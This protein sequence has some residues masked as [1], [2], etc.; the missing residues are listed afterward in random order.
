MRCLLSTT[1]ASTAPLL[2][3][4][5]AITSTQCG[6]IFLYWTAFRPEVGQKKVSDDI[7]SYEYMYVFIRCVGVLYVC[8]RVDPRHCDRVPFVQMCSLFMYL[9]VYLR[10]AG[11][12][13]MY[14]HMYVHC[15]TC[16]DCFSY[17][18]IHVFIRCAGVLYM[19]VD[20]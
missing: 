18:Y 10:C 4:R 13:Y 3:H 5:T 1:N 12:L 16:K 19:Y 20:L 14:V 11:V 6:P 8:V 9:Y 7:F 15:A 2:C 17:E